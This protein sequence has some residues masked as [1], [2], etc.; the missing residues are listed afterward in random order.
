METSIVD[1]VAEEAFVSSIAIGELFYGAEKS[2][3]PAEDAGQIDEIA[4][5][6]PV[7]GC[8]T[9]TARHYGN[10]Y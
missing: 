6:T 8:D 5:I 10:R 7:L 2:T 3:R 4:A 1:R 9:Q